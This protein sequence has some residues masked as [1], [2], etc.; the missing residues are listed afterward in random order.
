MGL[1]FDFNTNFLIYIYIF[2][3]VI[4][5]PRIPSF[6]MCVFGEFLPDF[7]PKN[8]CYIVQLCF[9]RVLD[10]FFIKYFYLPKK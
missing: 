9:E 6:L 5:P 3:A 8:S 7:S 10:F 1:T 2:I 4:I